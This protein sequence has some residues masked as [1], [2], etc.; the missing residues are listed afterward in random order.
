MKM[1]CGD[2]S[3]AFR[4][5]ILDPVLTTTAPHRVTVL[6]GIDAIAHAVET[7]VTVG[8]PV[9][10]IVAHTRQ[11]PGNLV[12]MTTHGRTGLRALVLGSVAR[13]VVLL[14][15]GPVLVVRPMKG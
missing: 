10:T 2:P 6:A 11:H 5:A 9:E 13:R 14:A 8:F 4:V 7:A 1:A 15:T 12:V 3:A